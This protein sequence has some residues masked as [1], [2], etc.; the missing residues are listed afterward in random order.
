[1]MLSN[2]I[3]NLKKVSGAAANWLREHPGFVWLVLVPMVTVSFYYGV[4]ASD[5]Y[6]SESKLTVKQ[7]D[8]SDG[9]SSAASFLLGGNP[10]AREDALFLKEY[11]NSYDMLSLLDKKLALRKAFQNGGS[12]ADLISRLS[13]DATREEFLDYYRRHVEI[14][15]D[16]TSSVITLRVDGFSPDLVKRMNQAILEQCEA[17][18]N[19]VSH[20]IASEQMNFVEHEVT[21]VKDRLEKAKNSMAEFQNRYNVLDPAEQ[22]RAVAAIVTDMDR[23][24]VALEAELQNL[25]TYLKEDSYQLVSLKNKIEALRK[26]M[27]YEKK[28]IASSGNER[29]NALSLQFMNIKLDVD[30]TL[31]MYKTTLAAL[32]KTRI[33]ASKKLKNVVIIASPTLPEEAEYPRRLYNLA[34]ILVVLLA[35]YGIVRLVSA[36]I[37]EHKE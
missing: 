32:E 8:R 27:E 18:M 9:G 12:S 1:M 16:E 20:K 28:L 24:R 22:A 5:R 7:S 36:T 34:T 19:D 26:Q 31:D 15:Y 11:I 35:V 13:P 4:I 3:A 30:F 2:S 37:K 17:Y 21:S 10:V 14:N 25:R 33:D 6:V 29:M 23:S